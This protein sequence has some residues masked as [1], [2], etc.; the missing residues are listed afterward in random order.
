MKTRYY[1]INI[2]AGEEKGYW[3]QD[4]NGGDQYFDHYPTD[5]EIDEYAARCRGERKGGTR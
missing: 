2:Y 3:I 5:D 4:D 1:G